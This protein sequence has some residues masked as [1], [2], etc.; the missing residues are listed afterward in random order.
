[1]ASRAEII[2]GDWQLTISYEEFNRLRLL[3]KELNYTAIT[4]MLQGLGYTDTVTE[5]TRISLTHQ[6]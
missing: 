3:F 2:I 1:M 6:K 4:E 5:S